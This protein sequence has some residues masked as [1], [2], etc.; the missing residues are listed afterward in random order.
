VREQFEQLLSNPDEIAS[1]EYRG[2]RAFG[3][4]MWVES[5]AQNFLDEEP[6][7][8]ILATLR[9]VTERKHRE[10]ELERQNE[11]LDEFAG[12][13][14]HDL[15]NPLNVV[16]VHPEMAA[17][18]TDND[19]VREAMQSLDRM[20]QLVED[21][22]Q[23]AQQGQAVGET[24]PVKLR[25]LAERCWRNVE[26]AAARVEIATDATVR[27]DSHRLRSLLENLF[28]N[29]VAHGGEDVTVTL[30]ILD[31]GTGFYVADDGAG[32]PAE[33]R[34]DIFESGH[35][36][37]NDGTGFGLAIVEQI[38][39]AHGWEVRIT[40]SEAGG[41]RIEITGIETVRDR[42]TVPE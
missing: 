10:R 17:E 7:D 37:R 12:V 5:R 13:V 39:D 31:G 1:A 9:E 30:G 8:G 6:I 18:E 20:E 36:T 26:T 11:R 38:A 33:E 27:A 14:S 41:A 42:E 28:H 15:Q 25:D 4:W 22:L 34:E 21:L 3:E 16:S 29:A 19:H 23:L 24:E 35:S 2:K 40:D 32:I